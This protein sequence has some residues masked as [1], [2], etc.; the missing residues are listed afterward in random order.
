MSFHSSE[1]LVILLVTL[2]V[3]KPKHLPDIARVLARIVRW[4]RHTKK[5]LLDSLMS[6]E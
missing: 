5:K 3:V 2:L 6:H 1:L 4:I